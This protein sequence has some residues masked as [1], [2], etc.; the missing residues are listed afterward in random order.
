MTDHPAPAV[1]DALLAALKVLPALAGVR[2]LDGPALAGVEDPDLVAVGLTI[3]DSMTAV[4]ESKP[5]YGQA[6]TETF[7]VA[8][9]AQS[10]SGDTEMAP[11]RARALALLEAVR[12]VLVADETV[13]G[14]CMRARIWRWTCRALQ[15]DNGAMAVAEFTVRVEATAFDA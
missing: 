13:S 4:G 11:R 7:D 8:C 10:W 3:T 9:L 2:V 14:T 6:R 1:L 12:S 5:R 15:A